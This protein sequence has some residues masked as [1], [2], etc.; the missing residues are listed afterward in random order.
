[1][2]KRLSFSEHDLKMIITNYSKTYHIDKCN[3][4]LLDI[5]LVTVGLKGK[6]LRASLADLRRSTNK[7]SWSHVSTTEFIDMF[8]RAMRLDGYLAK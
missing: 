2:T 1:M 6:R 8:V 7:G 5:W 3:S 4:E